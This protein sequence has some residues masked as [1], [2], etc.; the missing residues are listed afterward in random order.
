MSGFFHVLGIVLPVFLIVCIGCQLRH[1]NWL[2]R[3]SDESLLKISVNLLL[4]CLAFAKISD[5]P[6]LLQPD[7]VW[8][9]PLVGFASVGLGLG[10]GWLARGLATRQSEGA[11]PTFALSIGVYNFGFVPI[12]LVESLFGEA[13][14]GVLFVFNIGTLMA[15]WSIG[16]MLLHGDPR[17]AWRQVFNFPLMAIVVALLVN[18]TGTSASIPA[19]VN[20][21]ITL[22]GQCAIPVTMLLIG[23]MMKDYFQQCEFRSAWRI[24]WLGCTLRLGLLPALFL[25]V[26]ATLPC[27]VELKQ[28]LAVEA[29][30][31]SAIFPILM[32][33]L[34]GGHPVVATQ[35]A[36]TTSLVSLVTIPLWLR[37]GTALLELEL[38]P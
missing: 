21:V 6:A 25:L 29:A 3:E 17:T 13:T 35:V 26:A 8:L 28:V 15:M 19:V 1:M 22:L 23:A 30:M 16:V 33:R 38:Q 2:T 37:L 11:G 14:V 10:V 31:P 24:C 4:P 20:D 18:A 32:A 9:P 12:P 34:Y 7:N 36:I 5:N 27:T